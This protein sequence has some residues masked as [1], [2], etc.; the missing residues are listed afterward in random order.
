MAVSHYKE[1]IAWQLAESFKIEVTRLVRSSHGASANI[2]FRDQLL[3]AASSITSNI[4]EGFL[5][6]SPGH[7]RRFL[8]YS[9]ASLGEAEGRLR[10]GI[11]FGYFTE[12][13]CAEAFR[14]ARR[15]LTA[16]VRL[17]QGQRLFMRGTLKK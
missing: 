1:L 16:C 2:G 3:N 7:F 9:L 14:L 6:F 17:K 12:T 11:L 5:R 15:C 10:D 4:V 8:D 13:D